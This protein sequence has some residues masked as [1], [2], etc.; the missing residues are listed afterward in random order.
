MVFSTSYLD[1]SKGAATLRNNVCDDL[2][3]KKEL[4]IDL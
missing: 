4:H 3:S 1:T 2:W